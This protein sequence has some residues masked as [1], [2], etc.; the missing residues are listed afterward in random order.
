MLQVSRVFALLWLVVA[1]VGAALVAMALR[2]FLDEDWESADWWAFDSY[3]ALRGMVFSF[4]FPA[5]RG[6]HTR[7][8]ERVNGFVVALWGVFLVILGIGLCWYE[9]TR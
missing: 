4:L 1:A 7:R 9:A 8:A 3:F 2:V 6:P 5:L